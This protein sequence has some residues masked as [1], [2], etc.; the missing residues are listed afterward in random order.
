MISSHL[1]NLINRSSVFSIQLQFKLFLATSFD[2]PGLI[3]RPP[4]TGQAL[5][6]DTQ[7]WVSTPPAVLDPYYLWVEGTPQCSQAD[8]MG[9]WVATLICRS[10]RPWQ[11][12]TLAFSPPLH[13]RTLAGLTPT[14]TMASVSQWDSLFPGS[15]SLLQFLLGTY[16]QQ[17][18]G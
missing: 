9:R 14:C 18:G 16:P 11:Y 2:G 7:T 15:D 10:S 13:L 5:E 8:M 4:P 1:S 3:P 12:E 17:Y 6:S